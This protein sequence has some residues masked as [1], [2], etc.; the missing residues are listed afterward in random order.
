MQFS[1][2][3][4]LGNTVKLVYCNIQVTENYEFLRYLSFYKYLREE[5]IKKEDDHTSDKK[6]NNNKAADTCTHL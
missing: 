4:N 3:Q 1:G 2:E 5:L 6:L